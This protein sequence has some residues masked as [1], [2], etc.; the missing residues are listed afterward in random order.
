[1]TNSDAEL[2]RSAP[3]APA[4]ETELNRYMGQE[5]LP[6]GTDI[7]RYW[8]SKQYDY[9]IVARVARDYLAMPATSSPSKVVCS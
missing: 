1:M 3:L 8:K 7:Y 6:R 4:T 2:Y 9:P 5:R